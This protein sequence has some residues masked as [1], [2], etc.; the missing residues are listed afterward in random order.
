MILIKKRLL[1]IIFILIGLSVFFYFF[2]QQPTSTTNESDDEVEQQDTPATDE[3]TEEEEAEEVTFQ[4]NPVR[5]FLSEQVR[6]AADFF[7]PQD[8]HLVTLGDSLT[9]GVGDEMNEGGY[10]GILESTLDQDDYEIDIHNFGKRGNR[11]DQLLAR[12][13]EEE[14]ITAL[15]DTDIILITIGANDIMQVFKENLTNITLE[16]FNEEQLYYEQRL[17]AIFT[18]LRNINEDAE[19]Y[20]I[21]FYNPFEQYF[22]YIE[23]LDIIVEGWNDIGRQVATQYDDSEFIPIKDLFENTSY[24]LIAEYNFHPNHL[25]YRLIADRVLQFIMNEGENNGEVEPTNE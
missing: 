8:L 14:I 23:E 12:L 3:E 13:E 7:F 25:G 19:I 20:L 11:S 16:K 6:K 17:H 5:E 24:N 9:E 15:E 4:E 22:S 1:I 10:V 2:T 18:T 21:G